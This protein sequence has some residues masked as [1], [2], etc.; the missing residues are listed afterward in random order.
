MVLP[1]HDNE[2]H[3]EINSISST[4]EESG[5]VPN[6]PA[7]DADKEVRN[8]MIN[9][10]ERNVRKARFIVVVVGIACA[11]AVGAAINIFARRSEQTAF[12]IEVRKS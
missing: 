2:S 3:N 1:E 4:T 5:R 12:E 9:K 8:K 6:A 11:V 10:E 7:E